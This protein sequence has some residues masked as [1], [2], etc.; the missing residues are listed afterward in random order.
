MPTRSILHIDK[1]P[2]I[3][4]HR[5]S[6][7]RRSRAMTSR[8]RVVLADDHAVLRSGLRA[9][10]EMESDI[11]VIAEASNGTDAVRLL[12]GLKPDVALVDLSM[13]GLNGVEIARQARTL[14]PATRVVILSAYG[15]EEYVRDALKAGV[16]GYLLKRIEMPSL[17]AAIRL[18]M[19]GEV[20]WDSGC[21]QTALREP[22][23][24]TSSESAGMQMPHVREMEV[25][26]LAAAG[27]ANK[28]IAARL[29]IS[30]RT[31]QTH[32]LNTYRKLGVDNRASAVLR[33]VRQ[34]WIGLDEVS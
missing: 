21:A 19:A 30:Q 3:V 34:G 5:T 22:A 8:I 2:L 1:Q 31:V 12:E 24:R 26:R 11:E 32:L 18:A 27:R 20:V 33:A 4:Y 23:A 29:G 7:S 13:P 14:S 15:D 25:L 9:L 28:E 6:V 16:A 17:V 10:L